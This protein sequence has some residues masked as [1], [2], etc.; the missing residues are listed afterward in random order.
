MWSQKN[1]NFLGGISHECGRNLTERWMV[2]LL[3]SGNVTHTM[4]ILGITKSEEN[5]VLLGGSGVKQKVVISTWE[6][7]VPVHTSATFNLCPVSP[8]HYI[9][10]KGA[11]QM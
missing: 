5:V 11:A 6:V 3:A 9:A 1:I 10:F 2:R 8:G 7:P 4:L